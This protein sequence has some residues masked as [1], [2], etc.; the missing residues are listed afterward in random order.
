MLLWAF[1]SF[2]PRGQCLWL[3]NI[4]ENKGAFILY[5]IVVHR[6]TSA[7]QKLTLFQLA[8]RCTPTSADAQRRW[9]ERTLRDENYGFAVICCLHGN[10]RTCPYLSSRC[11]C[12]T[13]KSPLEAKLSLTVIK[14]VCDSTPNLFWIFLFSYF[15][16]WKKYCYTLI[17]IRISWIY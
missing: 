14:N 5:S 2:W 3:I 6:P 9:Y 4:L 1:V 8:Q 12:G 16:C 17:K 10:C 15:C 13:T 11:R 7:E